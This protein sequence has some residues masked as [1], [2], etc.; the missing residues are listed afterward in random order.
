[1]LAIPQYRVHG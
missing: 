1:M